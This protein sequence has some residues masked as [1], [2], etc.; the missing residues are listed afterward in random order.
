MCV[1]QQLMFWADGKVAD[2]KHCF[3][4]SGKDPQ[5]GR[6]CVL[7]EV[8][9]GGREGREGGRRGREGREGGREG[10]EGGEGGREGGR[11]GRGGREGGEGGRGGREGGR[12]GR[13]GREGGEGGE[14]REGGREKS[15]LC[16]STN[17]S[18]E[19]LTHNWKSKKTPSDL[20]I[21][22]DC[23]N[24]TLLGQSN[25]SRPCSRD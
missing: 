16:R 14:G 23:I 24:F 11:G 17:G 18:S 5:R 13:G 7:R 20:P 6:V 25:P 4:A 19:E 12:G 1:L 8:G 9:E 15:I 10:G 2:S 21:Q 22:S 3:W